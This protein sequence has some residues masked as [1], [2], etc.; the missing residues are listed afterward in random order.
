VRAVSSSFLSAVRGSHR[1]IFRAR[2]IDPGQSGNDP[3]GAV[4][5]IVG[6]SVTF[7]TTAD[8][9]ATL[10]IELSMRWPGGAYELGSPYG[11]EIFVERGILYGNGTQEY[12]GLGYFRINSVEQQ[13]TP[14]GTVRISGEDRMSSIRDGRNP[15]PIQFPA[16][17]PVGAVVD[18]LVKDVLPSAVTVYDFDAYGTLLASDHILDQDRMQFLRDLVTSYGKICYFDYNGKFQVKSPPSGTSGSVYT[19]NSGRNGVLVSMK[20]LI[21]RDSVY[22]AVVASGEPVG[23][24]APVQAI[25]Y[26]DAPGSPTRWG[27][28]FGKVPEFF[29]S[30]FMTTPDQCYQAA[31]TMLANSRGVP[32]AVSLGTVPNP[33][34]EGWDVISVV[35]TGD[36]SSETHIIDTISYSL[37]VTAT[38]GI[39][40]RKQYIY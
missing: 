40:T 14:A 9:N 21:S 27:G 31:A 30:S 25:A 16:G 7:S 39:D 34:L 22:N 36:G 18:F 12:V 24:S 3:H 8:V 20:R 2:V 15:T 4:I 26:D 29:S 37:D 6:G 28:N 23:E 35:Y 10:D 33:A 32:Y 1:A 13:Q 19:I 38:M 11:Q 17:T 5:P